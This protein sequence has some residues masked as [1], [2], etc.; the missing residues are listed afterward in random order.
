MPRSN[1]PTG[2]SNS[3]R[4]KKPAPN[5]TKRESDMAAVVIS[6]ADTPENSQ[7]DISHPE[8]S[9]PQVAP[10]DSSQQEK[11]PPRRSVID[12]RLPIDRRALSKPSA[13]ALERRRGPG[14]R[15]SDFMRSAEEGELTSEQFM[16]VMA[17]E[18]FKRANGVSYPAWTDV[19]EV[20]RLLGYRKTQPSSFQLRNAEDWREPPNAPANVRPDRWAERFDDEELDDLEG[21]G[22]HAA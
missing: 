14:R 16:F 11:S 17:I 3:P 21:L 19:L 4:G 20:M 9:S 22:E 13:A 10:T 1:D 12:R 6:K 2:S 7:P 8:N 18:E 15:R 5:A